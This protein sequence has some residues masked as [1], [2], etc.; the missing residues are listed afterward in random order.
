MIVLPIGCQV[1]RAD[2]PCR[3]SETD[4]DYDHLEYRVRDSS[5]VVI[6]ARAVLHFENVAEMVTL[7]YVEA[8]S[9]KTEW[10]W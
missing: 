5:S 1:H 9:G 7:V 6:A 3:D 2:N 8:E 4:C 10:K